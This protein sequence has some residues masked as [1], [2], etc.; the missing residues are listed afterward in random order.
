MDDLQVYVDG[1]EHVS[2]ERGEENDPS[3]V[4]FRR[5]TLFFA[6]FPWTTVLPVMDSKLVEN[7]GDEREERYGFVSVSIKSSLRKNYVFLFLFLFS[8]YSI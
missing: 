4:F 1:E 2:I 3:T 7:I 8:P 5:K 6:T